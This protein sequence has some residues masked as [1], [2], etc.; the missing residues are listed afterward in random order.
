[1]AF[2]RVA[3]KTK[4]MWLPVTAS[5]A[6]AEGSLVSFASGLLVAATASVAG[7]TIP[8]VLRK[9]I[10]AT[11]S[12]YAISGR[13]VPVEVPVEKNVVWKAPS[14]GTLATTT[15][16][17][18]MDLDSGNAGIGVN[19]AG[20]TYDVVQHIKYLSASVGHF[21]LNIGTDAIAK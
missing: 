14:Q 19:Q 20:G 21:I 7:N 13:L 1:M 12:D 18:F 10:A 15:V 5:T 4:V 2:S 3:G 8:G 6:I 17:T 16:G 9:A 11:D